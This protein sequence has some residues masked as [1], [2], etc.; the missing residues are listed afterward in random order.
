[1]RQRPGAATEDRSGCAER[2][3]LRAEDVV[4]PPSRGSADAARSRAG[5]GRAAA[6]RGD[7]ASP[8]TAGR[9]SAAAAATA[10]PDLTQLLGDSEARTSG[11]RR[12]RSAASDSKTASR[13]WSRRSAAGPIAEV[14]QMAAFALGLLGDKTARDPLVAV[15]N[16]PSPM[17]KQEA[18]LR[19]SD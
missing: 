7:T 18:L 10:A 5:R 1:M 14:K 17:V 12:W 9:G 15:L 3:H 19:L 4:D 8:R 6:G 11:A 16:D 2:S 13:R